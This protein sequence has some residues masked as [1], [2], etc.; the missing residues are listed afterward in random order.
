MNSFAFKQNLRYGGKLQ[1]MLSETISLADDY[2]VIKYSTDYEAEDA[3][4]KEFLEDKKKLRKVEH[5][6]SDLLDYTKDVQVVLDENNVN[7]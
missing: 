1:A 2:M 4:D 3:Q 7:Y 6:F 5:D